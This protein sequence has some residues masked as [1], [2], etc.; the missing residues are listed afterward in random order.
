MNIQEEKELRA[1]AILADADLE[2]A[3]ARCKAIADE[4]QRQVATGCKTPVPSHLFDE[5]VEKGS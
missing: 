3:Q 5:R 4:F 1:S 2:R